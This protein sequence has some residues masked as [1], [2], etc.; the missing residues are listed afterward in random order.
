MAL[1]TVRNSLPVH[2][3]PALGWSREQTVYRDGA[4]GGEVRW[5]LDPQVTPI[6]FTSWIA[7]RNIHK[8]AAVQ[9]YGDMALID[10]QGFESQRYCLAATEALGPNRH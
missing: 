3:L 8:D 9:T 10:H 4:N 2:T 5:G 1:A 6:L 7:T